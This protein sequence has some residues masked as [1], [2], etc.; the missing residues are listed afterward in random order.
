MQRYT[1]TLH[2][3]PSGVTTA[4]GGGGAS[5]TIVYDIAANTA[6][7]PGAAVTVEGPARDKSDCHFRKQLLNIIGN[8]VHSD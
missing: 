2:E 4:G 1:L 7:K 6:H 5:N 3:H 8:L